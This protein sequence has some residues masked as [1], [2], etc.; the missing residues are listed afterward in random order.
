MKNIYETKSPLSCSILRIIENVTE[1]NENI[2][3]LS[4]SLCY[5]NT[6]I[7]IINYFVT[8]PYI[9]LIGVSIM[10]IIVNIFT[11]NKILNEIYYHIIDLLRYFIPFSVT[12]LHLSI[13]RVSKLLCHSVCYIDKPK[14]IFIILFLNLSI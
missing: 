13:H 9:A 11:F 2:Q 4:E 6:Q 12:L 1:E 14:E 3:L 8:M 7:N 5:C 10:H